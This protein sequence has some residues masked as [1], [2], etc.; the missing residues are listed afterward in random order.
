MKK[1]FRGLVLAGVVVAFSTILVLGL[2]A[3]AQSFLIASA[4]PT[5]QETLAR[6]T[7]QAAYENRYT[8][9][10]EFP[11]FVAEVSVI[12]EGIPYHGLVKVNPDFSVEVINVN[13][14]EVRELIANQLKMEV[15][16][17]RRIP[18]D[19]LHGEANFNLEGTDETGALKIREESSQMNSSY[20]VKDNVIMQVNR[21]F[22]EIAVTVDTLGTTQTSEGYLVVQFQTTFRDPKTG[23]VLERE[24]VRDFYQ[25]VGNYR[26]LAYRAIRS[27]E[28]GNLDD[29][30]VPDI[31]LALNSFQPLP[32]Q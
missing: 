11:G 26:L 13:L 21:Q 14:E 2:P 32:K 19:N 7:F 18:F 23:E 16:H 25:K 17:R 9:D 8:W 5:S 27:S 3:Q 20:Q 30:L 31:T 4:P 15:I 24:D 28:D 6:N 29:K 12:Y 10:E 1:Q 22:G